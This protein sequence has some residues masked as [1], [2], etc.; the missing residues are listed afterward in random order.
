[1]NSFISNLKI[2]LCIFFDG[3]DDCQNPISVNSFNKF[4]GRFWAC[5]VGKKPENQRKILLR[6]VQGCIK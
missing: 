4:F 1:M 6:Q 3:Q 5:F 2:L